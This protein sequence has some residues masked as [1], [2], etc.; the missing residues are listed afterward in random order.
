VR[1][2]DALETLREGV[3]A[4]IDLVFLDG[5]KDLYQPVL[6]LLT[7]RLRPGA[8]VLADNVTTFKKT[9]APFT[10][11]LRSG[12][13]GFRS[14]KLPFTSGLEYAVRME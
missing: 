7:P 11:R 3:P 13:H 6:D 10:A 5:W 9:L 4:P 1:L 14:V 12:S 8:I 2:G